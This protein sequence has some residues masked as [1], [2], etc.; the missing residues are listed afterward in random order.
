MTPQSFPFR[1]V[2][3]ALLQGVSP[4]QA[5]QAL[6]SALE[7]VGRSDRAQALARPL[8]LTADLLDEIVQQ[9]L[10]CAITAALA[11][12]E[13]LF[14][15]IAGAEWSWQMDHWLSLVDLLSNHPEAFDESNARVRAAL[16]L[17]G[18]VPGYASLLDAHDLLASLV[19][20]PSL[21]VGAM[22]R[23]G[24]QWGPM[25]QPGAHRPL[26]EHVAW[27]LQVA[28]QNRAQRVRDAHRD[29]QVELLAGALGCVGEILV[30]REVAHVHR[31]HLDN[32]VPLRHG[33]AS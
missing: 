3:R 16:D 5:A 31:P 21:T 12:D 32:V 13:D 27:F 11:Q 22:R 20:H 23:G 2:E 24:G 7:A 15:A 26:E 8:V 33:R 14:E 9:S 17:M 28:Q 1:P 19:A 25:A 18:T 30:E 6:Q 10:Q 29:R 4:R